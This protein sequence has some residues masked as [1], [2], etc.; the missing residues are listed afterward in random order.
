MTLLATEKSE[1]EPALVEE[2]RIANESKELA[3]ELERFVDG[4]QKCRILSAHEAESILTPVHTHVRMF[5][6]IL[7]DGH[8]G[9]LSCMRK[10]RNKEQRRCSGEQRRGNGHVAIPRY[11]C[12]PLEGSK[13]P[14]QPDST[15]SSPYSKELNDGLQDGG[16]RVVEGEVSNNKTGKPLK[17]KRRARMATTPRLC[18]ES[19]RAMLHRKRQT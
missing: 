12:A 15:R 5:L 11:Q 9:R 13:T 2:I 17:K 16:E 14:A 8:K 3:E 4:A 10:A 7:H 19:I 18:P 6:K 1:L